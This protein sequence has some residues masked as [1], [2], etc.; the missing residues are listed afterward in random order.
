M[1]L[2]R[3][4]LVCADKQKSILTWAPRGKGVA[5]FPCFPKGMWSLKTWEQLS[6]CMM[7]TLLSIWYQMQGELLARLPK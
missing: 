4:F 3:I 6:F 2:G 5:R 1:K 7:S